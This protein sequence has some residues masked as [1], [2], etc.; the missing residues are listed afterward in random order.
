MCLYSILYAIKSHTIG[1]FE[2]EKF[3]A[4]TVLFL[5]TSKHF[6][7]ANQFEAKGSMKKMHVKH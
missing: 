5:E 4:A 1:K 7:L 2:I 6:I 3:D